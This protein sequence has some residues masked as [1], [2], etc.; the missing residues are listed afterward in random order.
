MFEERAR[1]LNKNYFYV[2]EPGVDLGKHRSD[3]L[4]NSME[5]VRNVRN[6]YHLWQKVSNSFSVLQAYGGCDQKQ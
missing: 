2:D 1:C 4:G 5:A 6:M 3:V